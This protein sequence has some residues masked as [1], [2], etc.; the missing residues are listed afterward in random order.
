MNNKIRKI[1]LV[2]MLMYGL[3]LLHSDAYAQRHFYHRLDV[4]SSNIY[5]FVVS[6]IV[7]GYANYLTHDILFDNSYVYTL[8]SGDID[9]IEIKTKGFGPM[10][11]TA[12]ELF[13]DSFGGVKLGYQSDFISAFNWGLYA[14]VHYKV[15]QVKTLFP[16]MEDYG[17]ERFQYLK[18]GV[19]VLFTF[20]DM[21]SKVKVQIE[22]A[23]RYD[24]P[25]GYKGMAGTKVNGVL[26]KGISSHFSV[27]VAGYSWLSA[28]LFADFNHYDLYRNMTE[29]SHFKPYSF[30]VT[31]TITPKR[32]EDL[33]D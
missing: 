4:G 12:R 28:G 13:N 7:T 22:A 11:V 29:G 18:P 3:I 9:G 25:M 31:F 10:G 2:L 1:F 33:Y 17:N 15:N 21:E 27:K 32:G 20:G 16:E 19:G 8:Y 5:T 30:G 6:N 14:S 26:N 23:A 24:I